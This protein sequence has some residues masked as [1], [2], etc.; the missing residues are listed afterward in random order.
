LQ[1]A[2]ATA[3]A[4]QWL[5][6][7]VQPGNCLF[8]TAEDDLPEIHRRLA[9]IVAEE[10]IALSDLDRLMVVSLAGDDALLAVPDGR[11]NIIRP[12]GL[13]GA[14]ESLIEKTRPALARLRG[15]AGFEDT[16]SL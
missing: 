14:L 11:S 8:L 12:T 16:H 2:A 9:D 3:T 5:G 7:T 6:R 10:G 15:L 13:F 1:L 4:G